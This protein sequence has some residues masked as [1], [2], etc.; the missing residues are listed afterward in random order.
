MQRG[1]CLARHLLGAMPP[2]VGSKKNSKPFENYWL[3][4]F[5]GTSFG[6]VIWS[7]RMQKAFPC[8]VALV[9]FCTEAL[10][11]SVALIFEF[12]MFPFVPYVGP[13]RGVRNVVKSMPNYSLLK[14]ICCKIRVVYQMS[15]ISYRHTT[16]ILA[17]APAHGTRRPSGGTGRPS[18]SPRQA[19][20]AS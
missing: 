5:R 11:C 4:H 1:A 14:S 9:S 8:S 18:V 6:G 20:W 12:W 10:P 15:S 17:K 3:G 13:S 19:C 7:I 2:S 16:A